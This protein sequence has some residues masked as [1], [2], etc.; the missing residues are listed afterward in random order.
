[1]DV[2]DF[3]RQVARQIKGSW[4]AAMIGFGVVITIFMALGV[5]GVL[6]L[7]KHI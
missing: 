2:D 7:V 3:E 4:Y 1:M 5:L 6:W